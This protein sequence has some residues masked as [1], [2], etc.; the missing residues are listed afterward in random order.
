MYIKTSVV[1]N[2][3]CITWAITNFFVQY[4]DNSCGVNVFNYLMALSIVNI[5]CVAQFLPLAFWDSYNR[6]YNLISIKMYLGCKWL[7]IIDLPIIIAGAF[8]LFSDGIPCL[9][10]GEPEIVYT[11]AIWLLSI[12]KIPIISTIA[13]LEYREY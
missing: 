13:Y 11:T 3:L 7:Y 10:D 2:I 1:I 6:D 9:K 12:F 4:E 8:I 5:L